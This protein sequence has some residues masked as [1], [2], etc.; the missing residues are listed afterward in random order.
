MQ[1]LTILKRHLETKTN[2]SGSSVPSV[3]QSLLQGHLTGWDRLD[4]NLGVDPHATQGLEMDDS[5]ANL[6][7]EEA[8]HAFL[9]ENL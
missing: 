9:S 2:A 1:R 6:G 5:M 4:A 7:D 8:G 3:D